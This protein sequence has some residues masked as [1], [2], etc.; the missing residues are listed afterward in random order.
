MNERGR[1]QLATKYARGSRVPFDSLGDRVDADA[2]DSTYEHMALS[3]EH[4]EET[5]KFMGLSNQCQCIMSWHMNP[6]SLRSRAINYD[7]HDEISLWTDMNF[8]MQCK[9]HLPDDLCEDINR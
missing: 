5:W 6:P 4:Y 9:I 3:L 8:I 7:F 1:R 2:F